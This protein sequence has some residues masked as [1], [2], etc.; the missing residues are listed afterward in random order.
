MQA[1][2]TME[3]PPRTKARAAAAGGLLRVGAKRKPPKSDPTG[4]GVIL[5]NDI[6]A[7]WTKADLDP[8]LLWHEIGPLQFRE[9]APLGMHPHRGFIEAPYFKEG[10]HIMLDRWNPNN[11][12]PTADGHMQWGKIGRGIEHGARFVNTYRGMMHV[13]QL[14]VNLPKAKKLD[15]PHFQDAQPGSLP[16]ASPAP[17][18]SIVVLLGSAA[19]LSSPIDQTTSG[20]DVAYVDV[21]LEARAEWTLDLPPAHSTAFV[22]VASGRAL[23]GGTAVVSGEIASLVS[24]GGE[25]RLVVKADGGPCNLLIISGAPL[26]EPIATHGPF[27]MSSKA[28][29]RQ[30]FLDYQMGRLCGDSCKYTVYTPDGARRDYTR[31]LESSRGR[32]W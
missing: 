26:G 30:A 25:R 24:D 16:K 6:L 27:V 8:F 15:E 17:G 19:G 32:C 10:P 31:T 7:P 5:V 9:T 13:F 14:W 4:S 21:D 23:V 2:K 28:E 12:E 18:V 20:T 11:G 29:L 22:Y 1:R 3:R